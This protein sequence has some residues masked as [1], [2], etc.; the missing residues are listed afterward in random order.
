MKKYHGPKPLFVAKAE[1]D[2]QKVPILELISSAGPLL[3][4]CLESLLS[5]K[6]VSKIDFIN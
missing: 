5:H 6:F 2:F 4:L 3:T 1:A